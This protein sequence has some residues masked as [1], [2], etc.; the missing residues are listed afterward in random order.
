MCLSQES[1]ERAGVRQELMPFVY[2]LT[3]FSFEFTVQDVV[4][5]RTSYHF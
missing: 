2:K 1:L 4:V 3:K 5:F